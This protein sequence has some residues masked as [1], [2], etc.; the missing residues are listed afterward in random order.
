MN[1]I[2][3]VIITAALAVMLFTK[4]GETL[5]TMV[6]AS[7]GALKLSASLLATYIIWLGILRIT[8]ATGVM[9]YIQ[10]LFKPVIRFLFGK[11]DD[12]AAGYLSMNFAANFLG[13]GNAA[14]PMGIKAI[15]KLEDGSETAS[16]NS[17]MLVVVNCA[18]VTLIPT[19]IISLRVAGG[20]TAA[21]D[22]I[23]PSLIAAL[24]S[25]ATGVLLCKLCARVRRR[26]KHPA[27]QAR[28]PSKILEGNS[29]AAE[30]S[31][32]RFASVEM[33]S[34]SAATS[35]STLHTPLSPPSQAPN[36]TNG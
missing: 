28:H 14:T 32:L 34:K 18:C 22:I 23:L 31:H 21:A 30:I 33:T 4:P 24:I 1:K 7:S 25:A 26:L 17:I 2:W 13:M 5:T 36:T 35:H 16:D 15:Q 9:K 10:R 19:T 3:T 8:E 6:S 27:S 11:I 29:S 20:S 12:E